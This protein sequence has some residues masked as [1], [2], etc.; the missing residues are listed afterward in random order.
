M[1]ITFEVALIM[2]MTPKSCLG[3]TP[4]ACKFVTTSFHARE[5]ETLLNWYS[6]RPE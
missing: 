2:N 1:T 4:L 5:L 3:T 6:L